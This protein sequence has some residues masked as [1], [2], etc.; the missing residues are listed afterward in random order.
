MR[1]PLSQAQKE[2]YDFIVEFYKAYPDRNPSLRDIGT[3]MVNGK[4]ICKPR[5][6]TR[7]QWTLIQKLIDKDY[8]EQRFY[9]NV[10]YW[11]PK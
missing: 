10:A 2:V 4:Q 6:S 8:L 1:H 3:G 9:R 7:S 11:V 5:K